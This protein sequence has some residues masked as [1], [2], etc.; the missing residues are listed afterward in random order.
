MA[1]ADQGL[2]R[3]SAIQTLKKKLVLPQCVYR[4]VVLRFLVETTSASSTCPERHP[5]CERHRRPCRRSRRAVIRRSR[6]RVATLRCLCPGRRPTTALDRR[7]I[8]MTRLIR[9][10]RKLTCWTPRSGLKRRA[11]RLRHHTC[12][13]EPLLCGHWVDRSLRL[14]TV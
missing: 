1:D 13:Y 14:R 8:D 4:A 2:G 10:M 12:P 6:T 3:Q 11:P 5:I 9:D 7:N